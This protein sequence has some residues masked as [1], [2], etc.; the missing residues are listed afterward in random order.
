MQCHPDTVNLARFQLDE[1]LEGEAR[2]VEK[3]GIW[4]SQTYNKF[5]E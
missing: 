3:L 5:Y 4:L 2:I 1:E